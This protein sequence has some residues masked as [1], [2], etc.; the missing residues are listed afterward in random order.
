MHEAFIFL[1]IIPLAI[2][3]LAVLIGSLVWAYQDAEKR[4]KSGW[5][6]VFMIFLCNWPF[7]LLIWLAFRPEVKSG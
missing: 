1:A 6:I 5:L 4:G 3:M 7:S 2:L